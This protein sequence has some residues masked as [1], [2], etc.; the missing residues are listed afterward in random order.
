MPFDFDFVKN[1]RFV[2]QIIDITENSDINSTINY[3]GLFHLMVKI[4]QLQKFYDKKQVL[5]IELLEVPIGSIFGFLGRNGAGKSTTIK[6]LVGAMPYQRGEIEIGGISIRKQPLSAKKLIGYAPDHSHAYEHLSG[7]EFI[8]FIANVYGV[9]NGRELEK[10]IADYLEWFELIKAADELIES[11]SHG[12]RS[13][14]TIISALVHEPQLLILDEPTNGLDPQSIYVLK[15]VLREFQRNGGTVFISSHSLDVVN[16]IA[17]HLAIIECGYIK[18][19]G[20]LENLIDEYRTTPNEE[21]VA[22]LERAFLLLTGR[23]I[24]SEE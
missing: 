13:K 9:P 14:I 16:Q 3:A 23:E 8:R 1:I 20:R 6:I 15:D 24:S 10:K 18:Y 2:S 21:T 5:A 12:M 17:D 11:Y 7:R 4:A 19:Q 22:V